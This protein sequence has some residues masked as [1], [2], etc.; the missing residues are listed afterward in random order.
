M[1]SIER[2][3]SRKLVP[4]R[5]MCLPRLLLTIAAVAHCAWGQSMPEPKL[6]YTTPANSRIVMPGSP[7]GI[8]WG[9]LYGYSGAKAET[10]MPQERDLGAGFTKVYL[11]WN[12]I[13]PEKGHFRWDAVDAFLNQLKSPEEGL[14]SLFSTSTWA[15]EKPG[16]MLPPSPAK[17][18][19]DYYQFV[20]AIVAHAKGRV[21]YWQNDSEPNS[22]IYWAGTKEQFVAALKIFHKAVKDADP[23]A[24][25]VAGGYDGLFNPPGT[26]PIPGQEKGL[27]FFDYVLKEAA[28]AFDVFDLRLYADPYT[29]PWRAD[30]IRGRMKAYGYEKPIIAAEY[31]GPGFYEFPANLKY[32]P[33]VMKWLQAI[34]A[35]HANGDLAAVDAGQ[36]GVE[37]LYRKMDTLDPRTQMFMQDCPP[38][39][40]AKFERIQ[41]RDL[42]MRNVLAF[43]AGVQKTL[44][45]SLHSDTPNRDDVM[46]L[47]FGKIA[48]LGY[49]GDDLKKRFPIADAYQKM[50]KALGGVESVTRITVPDH[51]AIFLFEVRRHGQ[52]PLYAIWEK[53]DVFSGED[54]PPTSLD[55]KVGRGRIALDVSVTPVFVE[56][57]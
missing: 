4:G 47:M 46:N 15:V 2:A 40:Q 16:T 23:A 20:H 49:E 10:F 36:A 57:K 50:A 26:H 42:V 21:R 6:E 33:L 28:D 12:Q 9:F 43:S 18:P 24:V 13:E 11:F 54:A 56:A 5:S 53:R 38:Q 51:P 37:E 41:A 31:G 48:M 34:S 30:Y 17:N 19:D 25:V 14:I 3:F 29:I 7:L 44:Y 55:F 45:W 32:G 8:A 1:R 39:L 27:E 35:G 52:G 22:S